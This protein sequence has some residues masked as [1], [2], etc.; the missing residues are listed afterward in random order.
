LN[1]KQGKIK[2]EPRECGASGLMRRSSVSSTSSAQSCSGASDWDDSVSIFSSGSA[3]PTSFNSPIQTPFPLSREDSQSPPRDSSGIKLPN[4]PLSDIASMHMSQSPPEL[5]L[6][7]QQQGQNQSHH[8]TPR[9]SHTSPAYYSPAQSG[10]SLMLPGSPSLSS[11]SGNV[12]TANSLHASPA[13]VHASLN[14]EFEDVNGAER[15]SVGSS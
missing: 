11:A 2:K 14:Q 5:H 10:L 6:A 9:K 12:S 4:N 1:P 7:L 3:P 15:P 8:P 13:M